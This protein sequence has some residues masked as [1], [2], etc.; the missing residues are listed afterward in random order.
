[1]KISNTPM[2]MHRWSSLK[3]ELLWIYDGIEQSHGE[4]VTAD[5]RNGYWLWLIHKG[6]VTMACE[7]GMQT[8]TAGQWMLSPHALTTQKFAHDSR[9]LSIHFSCQWPTGE[10]LF[11][12]NQGLVW[13]AM[14]TPKLERNAQSLQ[15]LA[16]RHC[17]S[18]WL[19]LYLQ[20]VS[21]PLFMR[22][23]YALT[24]FLI[25]FSEA[26]IRFGREFSHYGTHDD[27]LTLALNC[28]HATPQSSPFPW[29]YIAKETGL[30]RKHLDRLF[31]AHFGT[32]SRNY[33]DKIKLDECIRL[34]E[35]TTLSIKEVGYHLGFKQASHFST[36][37][38]KHSNRSPR[39]HRKHGTQVS[40]KG[41]VGDIRG[42]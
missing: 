29:E 8:A 17:P 10:N 26:M 18:V 21:Y 35:T 40:A 11:T 36:W 30:S 25:E 37:F 19:N 9:I 34:L 13:N 23:Q 24:L 14:D 1:M 5:H 31:Y 6:S 42:S 3:T 22:F 15:R 41:I 33:W 39:E 12:G 4:T 27:R 38:A 7:L 2:S 28:I 20:S 16:R 32:T